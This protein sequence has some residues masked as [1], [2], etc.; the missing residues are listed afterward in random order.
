VRRS[1]EFVTLRRVL[2]VTWVLALS[3]AV[4][5]LPA[6]AAPPARQGWWRASLVVL[7]IDLTTVLDPSSA[8]V[9]ADGLLVAGGS[10]FEEPQAY[11]AVAYD[12]TGRTPAGPLRLEP[13][14]TAASVPESGAVACPLDAA[15]FEPARGGR[16]E[17]GP[18]YD[19]LGAVPATIADDGAY[20][21]DVST[22]QRGD[23]VA[24]AVLPATTTSRIVFAPP[25]DDSLPLA[26]A[27]PDAP[28]P[29]SPAA[30]AAPEPSAGVFTGDGTPA[31]TGTASAAPVVVPSEDTAAPE[32]AG[33]DTP[34][35]TGPGRG[36]ARRAYALLG[37]AA[38]AGAA[39]VFAGR[40]RQVAA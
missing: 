13:H 16:V 12:V 14:P 27:G 10:S 9:P 20:L 35:P 22:L 15:T 8:D 23:T 29:S 32:R 3:G 4:V 11:A 1:G 5:S 39:W 28:A 38:A 17:D 33:F 25:G 19:C 37:L 31:P 26:P 18:R 24:V 40:P 7:G 6:S 34:I 21:F 2:L 36:S 30:A